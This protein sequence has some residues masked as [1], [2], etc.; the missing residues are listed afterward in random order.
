MSHLAPFVDIS[1]KKIRK[2]VESEMQKVKEVTGTELD[3]KVID[4]M[5]ENR[6]R[7]EVKKGVQTIQYQ[8][9]TLLSVNGFWDCTGR[10][11]IA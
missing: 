1:R 2:V 7:E 3:S 4:E 9:V 6:L 5:T 8:V 11:K 10:C